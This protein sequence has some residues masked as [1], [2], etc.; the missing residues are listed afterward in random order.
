MATGGGRKQ[1]SEWERNRPLSEDEIERLLYDDNE[2]EDILDDIQYSDSEQEDNCEYEDTQSE[3]ED[4]VSEGDEVLQPESIEGEIIQEYQN[5]CNIN[6]IL[7]DNFESND[8]DDI[9]LSQ[10]F[11]PNVIIPK[12]KLKG[13]DKHMWSGVPRSRVGRRSAKNVV[14]VRSG[15]KSHCQ[16]AETELEVF[17]L[18]FNDLM[19]QEIILYTNER[20]E[21]DACRYQNRNLAAIKKIDKDELLALIGLLFFRHP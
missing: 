6:E 3:N 5:T 21:K 8:E 7:P 12:L 9:P 19:L 13:K 18:F 4:L 10:I 15:P 1:L 14:Y 17:N 20:I 11:N 2:F 16:N